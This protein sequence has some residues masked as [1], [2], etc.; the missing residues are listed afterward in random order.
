VFAKNT[1]AIGHNAVIGE[2]A[3][4]ENSIAIGSRARVTG[5]NSIAIGT[6]AK[7]LHTNSVALGKDAETTNNN[8]I[9]L[10]TASTQVIVKGSQVTPSDKRLKDIIG[11][12]LDSMDK[13]N[14]LKVY[15][16]TFKND[17]TKTPRVGVIAQ[18]LQKIF[19]NAV[20]KDDQGFLLIR[21][22]DIFYAMINALKELDAKIKKIT[23]ELADNIKVVAT[24]AN[25][26]KELEE[27]NKVQ[28]AQI[29]ALEKEVAD[30]KVIIKKITK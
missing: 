19:P 9:M 25:K 26:I 5:M 2:A 29:K 28:D 15:D 16:F 1:I 18:E 4:L 7:A 12:N 27:K 21:R 17:K 14:R 20:T 10:G 6:D 13:I 24:N 22:E 30:L 8:Q 3:L 23:T 11:E